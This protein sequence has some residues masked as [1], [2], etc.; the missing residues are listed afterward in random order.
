[1][2]GF[3][4]ITIGLF[5]ALAIATCLPLTQNYPRLFHGPN[6][7]ADEDAARPGGSPTHYMIISTHRPAIP[8]PTQTLASTNHA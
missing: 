4:D 2:T 6:W 1:M 7:A 5:A 3:R 8:T